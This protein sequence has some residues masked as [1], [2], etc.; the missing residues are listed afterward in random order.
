[1]MWLL[2]AGLGLGNADSGIPDPVFVVEK[3]TASAKEWQIERVTGC[4][5]GLEEGRGNVQAGKELLESPLYQ[6]S[7]YTKGVFAL[8]K[9]TCVLGDQPEAKATFDEYIQDYQWYVY[10]LFDCNCGSCYLPDPV[11]GN[12][13]G[14]EIDEGEIDQYITDEHKKEFEQ[15]KEARIKEIAANKIQYDLYSAEYDAWTKRF[16]AEIHDESVRISIT[17]EEDMTSGAATLFSYRWEETLWCGDSQ[18]AQRFILDH[19]EVT[20]PDVAKGQTV[21]IWLHNVDSQLTWGAVLN[22]KETADDLMQPLRQDPTQ[23]M[24]QG[25]IKDDLY[26]LPSSWDGRAIQLTPGSSSTISHSCCS[27]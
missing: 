24:E 8:T 17:P 3:T 6:D 1:M 15:Y 7:S 20:L 26:N 5:G 19:R 2:V 21:H 12:G 18:G 22:G 16:K 11:E 10:A 14:K 27:C 4:Y 9:P 13:Y 23:L 25:V